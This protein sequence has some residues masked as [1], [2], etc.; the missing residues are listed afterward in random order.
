VATLAPGRVHVLA[1]DW[2]APLVG[3]RFALVASNPP[4][5][6]DSEFAALA[7]EV[8]REPKSALVAGPDGL[9]DVRRLAYAVPEVLVSGGIWL[10]EVGA[11]QHDAV[12]RILLD[13]GWAAPTWRRDLAG[14]QRAFAAVVS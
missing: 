13:A 6:A 14:I 12:H 2:T 1:G 5:V 9:E 3:R 10:C 7:P 11:G 4:Y 8:Q